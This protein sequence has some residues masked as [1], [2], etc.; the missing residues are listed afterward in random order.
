MTLETAERRPLD[1]RRPPPDD[2][3]AA[4]ALPRAV[5]ARRHWAWLGGGTVASFLLPFALAD[6]LELQRDLYYGI[7]AVAVIAL[8]AGW[9]RNTGQS[10]RDICARRWRVAVALGIAFAAISVL[11]VLAGEDATS[12]PGGLEFVG[13]IVW[14][15]FVY[16]AADGLL[17]RRFRSSSSLPPLPG[18]DSVAAAA[19]QSPSVRSRWSR[20]LP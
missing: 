2:R 20:H 7:Y 6:Q 5:R 15:G 19:E 18:A 13:A 3:S 4:Q 1:A 11:I 17:C 12:H 16:G 14:R 8:F 9:A 10:L